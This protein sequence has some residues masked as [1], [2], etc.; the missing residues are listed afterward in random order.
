MG[1]ENDMPISEAKRAE[2][3]ATYSSDVPNWD[4]NTDPEKLAPQDNEPEVTDFDQPIPDSEEDNL[5]DE[6]IRKEF[7]EGSE[8]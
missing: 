5:G 7:E 4:A 3:E 1:H 2:R 6:Q 8:F